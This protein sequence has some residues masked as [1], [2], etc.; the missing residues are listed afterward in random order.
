MLVWKIVL[1]TVVR[2]MNAGSSLDAYLDALGNRELRCIA[3]VTRLPRSHTSICGPGL[4][5][6][7]R[8]KKTRAAHLYLKLFK[9]LT[10]S[11][12]DLAWPT[13]W[14]PD[15]HEENIFVDPADPTVITTLID[16]QSTEVIPLMFQARR[17]YI[18]D[19]EG[20]E[21]E[22]MEQPRL[23]DNIDEMTPEED[24]AAT[25]LYFSQALAVAYKRWIK[26]RHPNIWKALEY[27][28]TEDSV[29]HILGRTLLVDGE[30]LFV[31][32]IV[33]QIRSGENSFGTNLADLG[34][35]EDDIAEI[36]ADSDAALRSMAMMEEVQAALGPLFPER[37]CVRTEHY[38]AAKAALRKTKQYVIDEFATT[39]AD[40]AAWNKSWPFDD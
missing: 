40:G 25:I 28:Q 27:Q 8:Q 34:I 16:W 11:D 33:E 2:L 7:T 36:K 19:H 4:Y 5:Q 32:R 18:L 37:G 23:P 13:A 12:Q 39:A 24:K 14:H 31:A 22:G 26:A 35:S 17:P 3:E 10:P 21:A 20:P 38:N 9:A 15:L 30:A 1:C 6:P 29:L